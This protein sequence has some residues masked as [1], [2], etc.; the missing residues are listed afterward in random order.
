MIVGGDDEDGGAG[1]GNRRGF[2]FFF[3]G[4]RVSLVGIAFVGHGLAEESLVV[5]GI[6]GLFVLLIVEREDR[7]GSKGSGKAEDVDQVVSWYY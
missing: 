4:L 7:E 2:L 3:G 1:T 6:V 5:V